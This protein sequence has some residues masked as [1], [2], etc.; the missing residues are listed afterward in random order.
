MLRTYWNHQT[1]GS[2][3]FTCYHTLLGNLIFMKL[4]NYFHLKYLKEKTRNCKNDLRARILIAICTIY[5]SHLQHI[6]GL[7]QSVYIIRWI[8][9]SFFWFGNKPGCLLLCY[10]FV[11]VQ[12]IGKIESCVLKIFGKIRPHCLQLQV[13]ND[14]LW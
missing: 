8:T 2:I 7:L 6:C 13:N 1:D 4:R 11:Q 14:E 10:I 9:C 12:V 5:L 3:G